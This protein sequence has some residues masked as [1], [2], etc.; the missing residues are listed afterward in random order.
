MNTTNEAQRELK[1]YE[2]RVKA[3]PEFTSPIEE[4]WEVVNV[5]IGW[6]PNGYVNYYIVFRKQIPR[7]NIGVQITGQPIDSTCDDTPITKL[8]PPL[9][10]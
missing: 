4:G 1:Y 10:K 5:F 8:T 3:T 2:Y 7:E 6:L 9:N